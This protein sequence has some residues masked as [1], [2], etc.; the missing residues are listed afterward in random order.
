MDKILKKLFNLGN[1]SIK[2]KFLLFSIGS[3]CW[4]ILVSAVGLVTIFKMNATSK[5]MVDELVPQ[6]KLVNAVIRKL[7]GASISVHKIVLYDDKDII[8]ENY[9]KAKSRI[10]DCRIYLIASLNG[11]TIKDYS[12]ATGILL[13]E[14]KV[15]P[16]TTE[17][18]RKLIEDIILKVE[19]LG[20]DIDEIVNKK[21]TGEKRD[22]LLKKISEYDS[23]TREM[24]ATLQH[25][26][27][28]IYNEWK[29]FTDIMNRRFIIAVILISSIFL[30]TAVLS[31][32][33]SLIMSHN[34]V[35][36]INEIIEQFKKF[37]SGYIQLD[38]RIDIDSKDEVGILAK[39]FNKVMDSITDLSSF[40][41]IIEEDETLDDIYIRL[42]KIF[43]DKLK[44]DKF[45]IYE[46][47]NSKNNMRIVF[48]TEID[49]VNL[50]CHRDI[51]LDCELC[52]VKRTGRKVSSIDYP[53][54]CKYYLDTANTI[55]VCI[56][57]ISEGSVGGIVQFIYDKSE[58]IDLEEMEKKIRR[59]EQYIVETQPV[60]EAKRLMKALKESSFKDGLT[61]L[62]NR[63]FLEESFDNLVAGILRR[64]TILGLLMCDIDFF[65]QINDVYGH[66]V[67]DIVL[68]EIAN[69]IKNCVRTSDMVFRFGGEEFLV[70][71]VDS[72][73]DAAVD[74]AEKIRE[75]IKET[76]IKIA[77]GFIQKTIS[78]GVSEFPL[79]T[80]NFW[81]AIKFADVALYKAKELGR[82]RVIR[83]TPDM[84][85]EENY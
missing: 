14:F 56:P 30:T 50:F 16:L 35:K 43:R 73:K 39:E 32:I 66:D 40:K 44:F 45:I 80:Q 69:N 83:F 62:Y 78:I 38:K 26:A 37:A 59:A 53:E 9:H 42:G 34:L 49:E 20:K 13:D 4:L 75:R 3:L 63:R 46:V 41:K 79:D 23:L 54:I 55:H 33:F 31:I 58:G 10:E 12:I 47:S 19:I 72:K 7:R 71:L 57:I 61:G 24:V 68:K 18:K 65:K 74:V 70:L 22:L 2:Q 64:G 11:G 48:P 77:G 67:G 6:E 76:K 60:I 1:L 81:E 29:V 21:L 82:N 27:I 51:L 15:K 25:F 8:K 17:E 52:R 85:T 84:W 36:N 5:Q 28:N